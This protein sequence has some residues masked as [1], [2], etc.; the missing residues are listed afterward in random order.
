MEAEDVA[1]FQGVIKEPETSITA[2]PMEAVSAAKLKGATSRLL[3]VPI[4]APG[5]AEGNDARCPDATSQHN[6]PPNFVSNMVEA[7]SASSPT[8]RRWRV[9]G[10]YTA[11]R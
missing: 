1:R 10:R 3:E 8:A 7:K 9:A 4:S 5:T 2:L 6:L 11:L